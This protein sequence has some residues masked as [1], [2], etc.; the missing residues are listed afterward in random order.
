[1]PYSA[2]TKSLQA[3]S[4]S[5]STLPSGTNLGSAG[6]ALSS[7][8][9]QMSSSLPAAPTSSPAPAPATTSSGGGVSSLQQ[10]AN[11]GLVYKSPNS[12]LYFPTQQQSGGSTQ[13]Q[14]GGT[15]PEL[16]ALQS[17]LQQKQSQLAEAQKLG[18][19]PGA[20]IPQEILSG[21]SAADYIRTSE[22]SRQRE[23]YQ[24]MLVEQQKVQE[25]R[26][27]EYQNYMNQLKTLQ[28]QQAPEPFQAAD[29]HTELMAQH[30]IPQLSQDIND[31]K[32]LARETEAAARQGMKK[33]EGRLAPMGLI[34]QRQQE[35]LTRANEELDYINRQLQTKV[36]EYNTKISLIGMTMDFMKYDYETAYKHYQDQ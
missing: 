12:G 23:E 9:T 27:L 7:S 32:T 34:S 13:Q 26:D 20:H 17:Q 30:A 11:Q 2:L 18:L 31:L 35:V 36:D 5:L 24:K 8:L 3:L 4:K 19:A 22:E 29:T 16:A 33:Q 25:M 1:M 10:A 14:P 28:Q 15:S 6:S 21:M